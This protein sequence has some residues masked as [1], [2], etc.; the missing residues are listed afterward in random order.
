MKYSLGFASFFSAVIFCPGQ[1]SRVSVH[2]YAALATSARTEP[3]N[4]AIVLYVHHTRTLMK[5]IPAEGASSLFWH[6]S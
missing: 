2:Y 6:L 1:F 3:Q 4:G 5:I